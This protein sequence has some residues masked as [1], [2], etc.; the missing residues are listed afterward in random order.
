MLLWEW[1][2]IMDEKAKRGGFVPNTE[3]SVKMRKG[4]MQ[5]AFFQLS[6]SRECKKAPDLSWLFLFNSHMLDLLMLYI[7]RI[8]W[9][10]PG[11]PFRRVMCKMQQGKTE[12]GRGKFTTIARAASIG[13]F[14]GGISKP[15]KARVGVRK[16]LGTGDRVFF[17]RCTAKEV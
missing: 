2:I 16:G 10:L 6:F 3:S 8:F 15:L 4:S 13:T 9:F 11:P 14:G 1:R 5:D 17:E 7:N 12:R